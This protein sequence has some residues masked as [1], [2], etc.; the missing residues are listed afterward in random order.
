MDKI[1]PNPA[2]VCGVLAGFLANG[3]SACAATVGA[4]DLAPGALA[5]AVGPAG[6]APSSGT[7][8]PTAAAPVAAPAPET[9]FIQAFDVTGVTK[10][11]RDEVERL[12]YPRSGP[13]RTKDDVEAARKA[14]QDAYAAKGYGAVIVDI[15]VQDHD[16]FAQG[17]VQLAVSEVPV[18]QLRVT[19]SRF[20]SL[21]VAREQV[22][23]LAEGEPINLKA[24][25]AEVSAANHFPDRTLNPQFKPGK[26][27]G[28]L[29]VDLAMTDQH[30][31]HANFD[32][33]NDAAPNTRPLRVSAGV[34][35][36]NL[37]QTGQSI[38]ATYVVA[39]EKIKDTEVFAGSYT[40]PILNSPWTISLSGYDS[41]SDI[42]SLGGSAVLGKGFQVGGRLLYRLTSAGTSQNISFGFDF[43]DFKQR[44][45]VNGVQ[46]SSA[47][48][49]YVPFEVQY[50]LSGATEHTSYDLSLGTTIGLRL[51]HQVVCIPTSTT[52]VP[53]DAFQNREQFSYENFV[54]G[55]LTADFSYAFKND[56]IAALKLAA[57]IADSHLISNEQFAAGGQQTVRGYYSSEAVGDT[58]IEPS[59][60][61]RSPSFATLFGSWLSEARLY[62]FADGAFLHVDDAQSGQRVGYRLMSI[63]G[64]LR[65]RLFSHFTG[66]VM[67]GVP[68]TA[69]PSTK[70]F[71]P[72]VNF[73]VKG[74]F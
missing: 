45:T 10:L 26:V 4:I 43:K 34:R 57:Q 66:E 51:F 65:T 38:S 49:K 7:A 56:M 9:F 23:S 69:G 16:T 70:P 24:L 15:P 64:G 3:G 18:G 27:P 12:V 48:I 71:H 61:L 47:P 60:E 37:F 31:G 44:I 20:H 52:C 50:A 19:G 6:A 54:R 25:Q 41:N 32:I 59:L 67:G 53:A 5:D 36:T 21:S 28:E 73:Q 74:D 39:P 30:P 42:A 63:G 33:N 46:A 17:V 40:V 2:W 11:T 35:Y 55:N 62:T 8:A 68:I 29:D 14:L 58:G 22:P 1:R 72:R 13:G